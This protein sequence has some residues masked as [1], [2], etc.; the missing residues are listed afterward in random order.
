MM[1]QMSFT[2][3]TIREDRPKKTRKWA[4]MLLLAV[5]FGGPLVG[6]YRAWKKHHD[7]EKKSSRRLR[8]MKRCVLILFAVLC[9]FLLVAGVVKGLMSVK[10]ITLQNVLEVTGEPPP[11]D[12]HG[13]INLLLLGQG[14]ADHDGKDLTDT[15]MVAS[16]DPE[17]TKSVTLLSLPRDLYFLKTE[18]M[19]KG[20][21][22][23]MYR[24]YKGYVRFREGKMEEEASII[25]MQ[26]LAKEIG[27]SLDIQLDHA[28]KVD[29]T[30]F[31]KVVDAVGGVTIDVAEDILDEQYPDNNWGY[32]TFE[33]KAGTHTLDG[34]TA[35]KYARSRHGS[36]DFSRSARQQQILTA[37]AKQAEEKG[38]ARKPSKVIDVY[39]ILSEHVETTLSL[40]EIIGLVEVAKNLDRSKVITAQLNDRNGLYDN[41]T[42]KGGLLYTPPRSL[43]DGVSVLLPVSTPEFPITW[44]KIRGFTELLIHKRSLYL[45]NP[46]VSILNAGAPSG[47]AGRLGKELQR[48]GF[49]VKNVS[50]ASSPD[51]PTSTVST[52]P[53]QESD[54]AE[55]LAKMMEFSLAPLPELPTDERAQLT[56]IL[57]KDYRYSPLQNY[58][59]NLF[60]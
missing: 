24:D 12:E 28:V 56:I 48:Y 19:G 50:N 18:K 41:I 15:I 51:Q 5:K 22:N 13:Y 47:M 58:I 9:C 27:R 11:V 39:N 40:R 21:L 59:P 2:V 20:K 8:L 30:A 14:D 43:F 17:Q 42:H 54:H 32:E 44:T 57:G 35:L 45:E 46:T 36:S 37:L 38:F 1:Y 6:W 10:S 34:D 60:Q 52:L 23:S 29:F 55:L 53:D 3:R 49:V 4:E 33:L 7:A 16:I 25:A 31:T 26:E